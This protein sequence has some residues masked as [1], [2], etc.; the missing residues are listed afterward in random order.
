LAGIDSFILSSDVLQALRQADIGFD[1]S[2]T[3]IRDMR[4]I[5]LAM[6]DTAAH[7]QR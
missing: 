7:L 4:L 3:S 5:L 1:G 2:A 6:L